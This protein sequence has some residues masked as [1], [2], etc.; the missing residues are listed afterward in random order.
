MRIARIPD[1]RVAKAVRQH[2]E[3]DD[4]REQGFICREL[5][6]RFPREYCPIHKE[7]TIHYNGK[8]LRCLHD[9]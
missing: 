7:E 4:L 8:C 2:F 1:L 9:K 5:S 3:Q 6:Q